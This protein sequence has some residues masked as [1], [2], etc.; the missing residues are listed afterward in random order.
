MVGLEPRRAE[1]RH[2][3]P[4]EVQG[5][6]ATN[7]LEHDAD[8]PR[9]LGE[10]GLRTLQEVPDLRSGVAVPP[11]VVSDRWSARRSAYVRHAKSLREWVAEAVLLGRRVRRQ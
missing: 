11:G 6:K 3:R 1:D 10:A 2:A 8:C 5:T 4:D 7:E 9:E